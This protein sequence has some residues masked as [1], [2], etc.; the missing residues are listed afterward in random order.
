MSE[1]ILKL[2]DGGGGEEEEEGVDGEGKEKRGQGREERGGEARGEGGRDM[3]LN[4]NSLTNFGT[5]YFHCVIHHFTLSSFG[6]IH[7]ST[8]ENEINGI[9]GRTRSNADLQIPVQSAIKF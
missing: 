6:R 9:T 8:V 1:I 5:H 3:R 4:F 2:D 7:S